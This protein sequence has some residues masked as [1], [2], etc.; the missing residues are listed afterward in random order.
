MLPNEALLGDRPYL[1]LMLDL[2]DLW[3]T[4]F[5]DLDSPRPRILHEHFVGAERSGEDAK[6]VDIHTIASGVCS[7]HAHVLDPLVLRGAKFMTQTSTGD[8]G[9][10]QS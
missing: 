5:P 3:K 8:G 6:G 9:W 1:M 7:N 2:L 4:L 10:N